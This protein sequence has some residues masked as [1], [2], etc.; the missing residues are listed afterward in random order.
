MRAKY[1][2]LLPGP[3]DGEAPAPSVKDATAK[4]PPTPAPDPADVAPL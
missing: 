1:T 3:P 2:V 4:A